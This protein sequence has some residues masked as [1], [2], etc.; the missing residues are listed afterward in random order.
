L[1]SLFEPHPNY[2]YTSSPL[3]ND[4]ASSH[5]GSLLEHSYTYPPM[6][7]HR[8]PPSSSGGVGSSHSSHGHHHHIRVVNRVPA[9]HMQ[10][11]RSSA[12]ASPDTSNPGSVSNDRHPPKTRVT[13]RYHVKT[14]HQN[15]HTSMPHMAHGG[16]GSSSSPSTSS[17][18]PVSSG[19]PA[20]RSLIDGSSPASHH[21]NT[22]SVFGSFVLI[23]DGRVGGVLPQSVSYG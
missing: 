12:S 11:K 7:G 23:T 8:S 13:G 5:H 21:G 20:G 17:A 9:P 4:G 16:D 14:V 2:V 18:T 6:D 3:L 19:A 22:G 1:D 10:H 15:N